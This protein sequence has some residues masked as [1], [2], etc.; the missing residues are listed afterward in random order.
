MTKVVWVRVPFWAPFLE[1]D[2]FMLVFFLSTICLE[3]DHKSVCTLL[4]KVLQS[5]IPNCEANVIM[6]VSSISFWW[7]KNLI[8]TG[9]DL[10]FTL[11]NTLVHLYIFI[12]Y[13]PDSLN[14]HFVGCN[15]NAKKR[16]ISKKN[17]LQEKIKYDLN[18]EIIFKE[19]WQSGRSRRSW[20]PLSCKAPGVRIPLSP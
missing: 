16:S 15:I 19:S 14:F 9:S 5:N 2:R 4:W 10:L 20:K 11:F 18:C 17:V 12:L 7:L 3:F 6:R 13:Y 1:K 8:Q